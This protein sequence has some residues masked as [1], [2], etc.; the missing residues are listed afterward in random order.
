MKFRWNSKTLWWNVLSFAAAY[1]GLLP[2]D[3]TTSVYVVSGLNLVLR[4][5]TKGP[6]VVLQDAAAE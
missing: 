2:L 3:P 4:A 5:L 6:L 1:T